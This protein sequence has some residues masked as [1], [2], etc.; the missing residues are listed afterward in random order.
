MKG[1]PVRVRASALLEDSF[2]SRAARPMRQRETVTARHRFPPSARRRR[3]TEFPT[4]QRGIDAVP[5]GGTVLMRRRP[6]RRV[7]ERGRGDRGRIVAG[8]ARVL[9]S[10]Q[11]TRARSRSFPLGGSATLE[12]AALLRRDYLLVATDSGQL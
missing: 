1:S 5:D 11:L 6:R 8:G 3:D 7:R 10:V 9:R 4:I 12:A 2:A